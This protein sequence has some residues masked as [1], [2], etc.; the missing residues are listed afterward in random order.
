VSE[1]D[2]EHQL[3]QFGI[4]PQQNGDVVFVNGAALIAYSHGDQATQTSRVFTRT[5]SRP[6]V[7]PVR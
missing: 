1:G 2:V 4:G 6:R 7:R 3:I 5:L